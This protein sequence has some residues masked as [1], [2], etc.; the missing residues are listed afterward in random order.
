MLSL[1]TEI[2]LSFAMEI[3]ELPFL[4]FFLISQSFRYIVQSFCR[5][6]TAHIE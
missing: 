2:S 6:E 5:A 4:G 1:P 3:F